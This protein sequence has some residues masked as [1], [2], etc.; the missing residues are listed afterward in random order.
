MI[1]SWVFIWL[2]EAVDSPTSPSKYYYVNGSI[3]LLKYRNIWGNNNWFR[4][5]SA[6]L[7]THG[8]PRS[9]PSGPLVRFLVQSNSRP[10][11][12]AFLLFL[13]LTAATLG[14]RL[15]LLFIR[16]ETKRHW[17]VWKVF[18][19]IYLV[20]VGHQTIP[21]RGAVSCRSFLISRVA[22]LTHG[23]HFDNGHRKLDKWPNEVSCKISVPWSSCLSVS[24]C[25][26][27]EE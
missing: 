15:K 25:K 1:S 2:I 27:F 18:R 8:R 7:H 24:S 21:C 17:A 22:N 23:P 20:I 10:A 16:S 26:D 4:V 14:P 13:L 19:P 12:V 6:L 5:F 9:R 11:A 3:E